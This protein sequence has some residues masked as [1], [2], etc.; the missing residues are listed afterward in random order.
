MATAVS[1]SQINLTW[2]ASTDNVKV[3]GYDIYRGTTSGGTFALAGT[4]TSNSFGDTGLSSKTTY[5]YYVVAFDTASPPNKS[6]N[7]ATVNATTKSPTTTPTTATVEGTVTNASTKAA[8]AGATV[9]T[10]IHGTAQGAATATTNAVGAYVL[11]N[12][13]TT[14][15]HSYSYTHTGYKGIHFR[16]TFP[17]GVNTVNEALQP[18]TKHHRRG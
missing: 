11:S 10:G 16:K 14:G 12:I 15:N 9:Q 3:S 7:S 1:T 13:T 4:A 5:Y 2:T 17:I 6:A 8:L 18:Q